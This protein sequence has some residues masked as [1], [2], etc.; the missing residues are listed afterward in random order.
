KEHPPLW[1]IYAE[2]IEAEDTEGRVEKIR[3]EFEAAQT[4]A[5]T[6]TKKPTLREL[7][8]YWQAYKGGRYRPEYEAATGV[9]LEELATVTAS[10]TTYPPA[11]PIPSNVTKLLHQPT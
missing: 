9:S 6:L 5:G 11:F 4:K 2:D 10:L 1:Q 7:P 3:A 8:G